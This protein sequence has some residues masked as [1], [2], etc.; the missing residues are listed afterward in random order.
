MSAITDL[1][2][3]ANDANARIISKAY[4]LGRAAAKAEI[5][6]LL[7]SESGA[8]HSTAQD[9]VDADTTVELSSSTSS[10]VEVIDQPTDTETRKRAP[11]GLPRVL[12]ERVLRDQAGLGTTP[13][14]IIEAAQTDHERMIKLTSIRSELKKGKDEGRYTENGGLWYIIEERT[15]QLG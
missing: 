9:V 3:E 1:I 8:H 15:E 11:R 4:E 10:D 12:A 5:L 6:A 14:E 13:A 7:S 2:A